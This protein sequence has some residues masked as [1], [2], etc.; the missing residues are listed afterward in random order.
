MSWTG[1][2][3]RPN[4]G[5]GKSRDHRSNCTEL[6]F[7]IFDCGIQRFYTFQYRVWIFRF[8]NDTDAVDFAI[9]HLGGYQ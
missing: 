2:N 3:P 5:K 7:G 4:Q 1:T 9:Y 8:W 6:C